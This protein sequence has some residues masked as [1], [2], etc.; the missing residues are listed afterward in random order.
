[1]AFRMVIFAIALAMLGAS[2]AIAADDNAPPGRSIAYAI[3]DIEW[4]IYQTKDTKEE[5][6][7][8]L[9]TLGPRE[10]YK[11]Q[12]PE[13]GTKRKLVD[14]QLAREADVWWP[15]MTPDQFEFRE[16]GGKIAM[17]LD[18]DGKSKPT[19]FTSPDGK[20]GIDNQLFRAIGCIFNYRVGGSV[21]NFESIY[22]K[23][24]QINRAVIVLSDVDS[25]MNDDDVTITTYRGL[26]PLVTDAT[27]N[28]F[29]PGGTQRLDTRWGRIFIHHAKGKI[30]NGVLM[31]QPMDFIKTHEIAYGDAAYDWLRDARFELKLTPEK[32]EGLIGGYADIETFHR[33]RNRTWSTH[34][35]SYGQ[36]ASASVYRVLRRLADGFP[37]PVTGENTAI[38][39]AYTVKMVQVNILHPANQVVEIDMAP[40][41]TRLADN[42]ATPA[43]KAK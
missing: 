42:S 11:I 24:M 32:A 25:L 19:D 23:K 14:T 17:G 22:Q 28:S 21:E 8:G 18:L 20:P 3:T 30:V 10:Q 5:C 1:M 40:G 29:Q 39:A 37:D 7:N 35:L 34:H 2:A 13:D 9:T 31:T 33:S 15:T 38:S 41:A 27:G 36:Q 6:P 26:D 16:G 12:F 4:A 43:P